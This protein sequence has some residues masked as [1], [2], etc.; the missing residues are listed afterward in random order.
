MTLWEGLLVCVTD[1][2]L[3]VYWFVNVS[4]CEQSDI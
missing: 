4:V 1:H 2:G 3:M